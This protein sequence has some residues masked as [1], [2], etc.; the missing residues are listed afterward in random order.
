MFANKKIVRFGILSFTAILA[1]SPVFAMDEGFYLGL[2]ATAEAVDVSVFKTV[3][4]TIDGNSSLSRGKQ[5]TERPTESNTISGFG[6]LAGYSFPLN[7]QGLYLSGE[8][9]LVY[10]GGK[11]SGTLEGTEDADARKTYN[12]ANDPDLPS[13]ATGPQVGE[14]WPERWSFEKDYSYGLT[15]RL[16]GQPDFLASAFGPGAGL[17]VLAGVRRTEAE[18]INSNNGCSVI[19]TSPTSGPFC[20]KE[21]D[22]VP[23]VVRTE[24][25][26]TAWT[27]GAG[28][29]AP[30][31]ERIGMHAEAYYMDYDSEPLVQLD[32]SEDLRVRAVHEPDA[33]E[34]GLRLKLLWSF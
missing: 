27:V 10:H 13:F 22:F 8:F 19:P 11:V 28:L 33:E 4:N 26:Y 34:Y 32:G 17:Y 24:K 2:S 9:D 12:D 3:D 7:D 29:H 1:G 20:L 23:G 21:T 31:T 6:I 5:F 18:Y 16:G 15:L 14:N 25:D 30:I